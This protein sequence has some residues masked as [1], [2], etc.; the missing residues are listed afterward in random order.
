MTVLSRRAVLAVPLLLAGASEAAAADFAGALRAILK[1]RSPDEGAIAFDI[2]P[3]SE[4]G[5]SVDLSVRVDSP[6]TTEDHVT[7]IHI[8][9]EKN[10][11]PLVATFSLTPRAGRAE[12]ATRIRLATS[13]KIVALAE[14]NRGV[15]HR[16]TR[17]VIVVLGACVETG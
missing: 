3:L 1:D 11:F 6:M 2:P 13:Q 12:V 5:N 10:P 7:A 17:D 4:N 8:L 14:T 15:V 9:A 16:A